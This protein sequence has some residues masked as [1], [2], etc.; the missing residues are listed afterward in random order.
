MGV[1]QWCL[2]ETPGSEF[3]FRQIKTW[4]IRKVWKSSAS[5][6][7]SLLVD[8]GLLHPATRWILAH[9]CIQRWLWVPWLLW[10]RTSHSQTSDDREHELHRKNPAFHEN[11]NSREAFFRNVSKS[12]PSTGSLGRHSSASQALILRATSSLASGSPTSK[13]SNSGAGSDPRWGMKARVDVR[14]LEG[15]SAE[16]IIKPVLYRNKIGVSAADLAHKLRVV[17]LE[18][19][20][21]D[22]VRDYSHCRIL[23]FSRRISFLDG[24]R[25]QSEVAKGC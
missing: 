18:P 10:L 20:P 1:R 17:H 13:R 15:S 9:D 24:D 3:P 21:A 4:I 5:S 25:L 19:Q 14:Q 6:V 2:R 16:D 23:M 11:W 12:E 22:I 7:S 8:V